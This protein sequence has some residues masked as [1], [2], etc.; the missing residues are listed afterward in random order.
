MTVDQLRTV[1]LV[2]SSGKPNLT[3]SEAAVSAGLDYNSAVYLIAQLGEG[4]GRQP[5]L[6]L[7]VL[8]PLDAIGRRTLSLSRAGA[9]LARRFLR[10]ADRA[11]LFEDARFPVD[12]P[13]FALRLASEK[14]QALSLGTLT[15]F[16]EVARLQPMFAYEGLAARSMIA[17]LKINNLP[18]HLAILAEGLGGRPGH[19]LIKLLPHGSDG[20]KKIPE[21]TWLG[22]ELLSQMAAGVVSE[23]VVVPK[24]PK[25]E[26]LVKLTSPQNIVDLDDDAFVEI[27][28]SLIS[29]RDD[30]PNPTSASGIND[31]QM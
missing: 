31:R 10:P 24:Y 2:A 7:V 29:D 12:G 17:T 23:K 1:L 22:H 13:I 16:L 8:N 20:R 26:F 5:G 19:R 15:V 25:P 27:D 28:F 11:K 6:G 9:E 3:Y 21:M 14:L 4:R 18:R 30:F